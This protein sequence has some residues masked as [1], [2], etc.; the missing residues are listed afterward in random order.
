MDEGRFS[1]TEIERQASRLTIQA[2]AFNDNANEIIKELE[3]ISSIVSSED[4]NLGRSV[5]QLQNS[6]IRLYGMIN[7]KYNELAD[8]M[9]RYASNTIQNE[10]TTT[11]TISNTASGQLDQID[12]LLDSIETNKPF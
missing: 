8:A 10:E 11:Q 2:Q 7:E 3:T 1:A 6:Y 12:E 9:H 5:N 4:S